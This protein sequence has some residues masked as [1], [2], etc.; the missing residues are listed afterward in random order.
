VALV[1]RRKANAWAAGIRWTAVLSAAGLALTGCGAGNRAATSEMGTAISGINVDVGDLALRD[2]RVDFGQRGVYLE[3]Q[4]APLRVW[5]DNQGDEPIV[6]EAVESP[7]AEAV[8]LAT[9]VILVEETPSDASPTPTESESPEGDATESPGADEP[10]PSPG[11]DEPSPSAGASETP[12]GET[13]S[14]DGDEADTQLLGEPEFAIEIKPGEFV[15]LVPAR[16]SFLL[17]EGLTEEVGLGSTV[18][19]TFFF[20]NGEE[21]TVDL[22]VGEPTELASRSYFGDP[23]EEAHAE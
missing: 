20:S 9:E 14:P 5:I 10:S 19:V 7:V 23:H 17:L 15:Q 22:P 11:A 1:E 8:T 12:T 3:G 16:G 4:A 2:L 13:E 6:L 21:V 18:E